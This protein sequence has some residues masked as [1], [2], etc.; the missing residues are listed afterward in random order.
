MSTGEKLAESIGHTESINQINLTY[1]DKNIVS[2]SND[3]SIRVW[4]T[5]SG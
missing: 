2:C 5:Q 1:D 4:S 3:K